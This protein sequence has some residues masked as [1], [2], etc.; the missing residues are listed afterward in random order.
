MRFESSD[1]TTWM[2]T[3]TWC[4]FRKATVAY[5]RGGLHAWS[6]CQHHNNS[7]TQDVLYTLV[8]RRD[9]LR[10][11][12]GCVYSARDYVLSREE[13]AEENFARLTATLS[14]PVL[15]TD[16]DASGLLW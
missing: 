6:T 13:E 16:N 4:T 11:C 3:R 9:H 14:H 8:C 10:D 1:L 2:L 7:G 5:A 12:T 15:E